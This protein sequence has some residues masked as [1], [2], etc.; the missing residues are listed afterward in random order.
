MFGVPEME[1]LCSRGGKF[2]ILGGLGGAN[3]QEVG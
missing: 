2:I 1:N 3:L